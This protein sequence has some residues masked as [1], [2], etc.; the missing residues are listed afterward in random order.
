[1]SVVMPNKDSGVLSYHDRVVEFANPYPEMCLAAFYTKKQKSRNR[2]IWCANLVQTSRQSIYLLVVLCWGGRPSSPP[3]H[4]ACTMWP[5]EQKLLSLLGQPPLFLMRYFLSCSIEKMDG[6]SLGKTIKQPKE[7]EGLQPL[8][9]S[10]LLRLENREIS[11]G[12]WFL[13]FIC[14][15]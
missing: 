8:R 3:G 12:V 5:S 7:S 2:K 9:S 1:M 10:V 6:K 15:L 14:I 13:V 4:R 11:W